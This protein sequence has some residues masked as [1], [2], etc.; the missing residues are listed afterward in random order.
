LPARRGG[1]DASFRL[2]RCARSSR[3]FARQS[4]LLAAIHHV[5]KAYWLLANGH[6]DSHLWCTPLQVGQFLSYN[7]NNMTAAARRGTIASAIET[8]RLLFDVG[9]LMSAARAQYGVF[10][11]NAS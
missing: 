4:T 3:P 6:G 11:L 9:F 7:L 1:D 10:D 5:V 8:H 2:K